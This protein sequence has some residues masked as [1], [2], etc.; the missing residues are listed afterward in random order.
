MDRTQLLD[1]KGKKI[2]FIDFSNLKSIEEIREITQDA[3]KYIHA[4]PPMS[5]F[6]LTSV[7]ETHFNSEIKEMFTDYI[8][9]NKPF[10][11]A[12]AITG[13]TGLKLVMYNGMMK[14]SGRDTRAFPS[15]EQAKAWLTAQM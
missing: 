10:V 14:I 11:K 15:L 7:E 2:L 5:V 4:Q 3:Q 13:V 6:T 9:S 1:Y 12:S 8:K